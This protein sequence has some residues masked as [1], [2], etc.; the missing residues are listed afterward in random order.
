MPRQPSGEQWT[1]HGG[2]YEAVVVEVGGGLRSC[3]DGG[4]P[5]VDGYGA[6]ERCAGGAGQVLAPW[7]NRVRDGKW[8]WD[9]ADQQL[10]LSEPMAGNAIHGLT[11]WRTWTLSERTADSVTVNCQ[12]DPQPGYPGSL[13]LT[14]QW[15]VSGDGLCVQHTALNNGPAATPFGLGVHPY[16]MVDGADVDDLEL[17]L[18]AET[19]LR[20]DERGLPVGG[21]RVAGTDVNYRAGRRIG[22]A[23]LDTAFTGGVTGARISAGERGVA[24]TVD[25]AFGWLQVFTGDTLP[26]TRRRRSVAI[27]PMTCPPDALNSRR[28][29]VVLQPEESWQ[30]SWSLRATR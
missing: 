8:S 27:E 3:T 9:G 7:P 28:D 14:T 4:R 15:R 5:I 23:V 18:A 11:R 6:A 13:L 17:Q 25:A 12:V 22:T 20:T 16:L 19:A 24:L 10:A 30:G 2:D 21:Y 29:L 26:G 1:L